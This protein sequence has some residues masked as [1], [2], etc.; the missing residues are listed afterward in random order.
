MNNGLEFFAVTTDG[1]TS[2]ANHSY[3][4]QTVHYVDCS[5]N[6]CT[7]LLDTSELSLEHTGVNLAHELETTFN[8][9]GLQPNKL[10]AITTDN[11]KNIVNAIDHLDWL[12][13][14]CFA[15]TL[16]LG[17]KK[18]MDVPQ[19]AKALARG[20]RLVSHFHHSAKSS[21]ILRQKQIDLHCS[22]LSLVQDVTT[23]WNSSYY[24][25]ER[26]LGKQQPLCAALLELR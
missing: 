18:A 24:M 16:Q 9:W 14:G 5:W 19:K 6:L 1:W 13:L 25:V 7:H 2:C 11:A 4:A 17:V 15:H 26:I 10:V 20:R 23:R 21:S 22:Q 3:V 8:Q 12:H